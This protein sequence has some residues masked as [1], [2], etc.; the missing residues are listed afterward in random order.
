V[1]EI[2]RGTRGGQVYNMS[3]A[4]HGLR[5]EFNPAYALPA[6]LKS[7]AESTVA[8]LADGSIQTGVK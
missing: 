2:E 6:E 3:F 8:G 5:L 1:D 4:N 7:L